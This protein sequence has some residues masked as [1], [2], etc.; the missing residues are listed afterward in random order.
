ML[1][2][3]FVP[4]FTGVKPDQSVAHEETVAH[5]AWLIENG[6]D[7]LVPFGTFGEGASLSLNER[8]RLTESILQVSRDARVVPSIISNSFG[9]I[10]EYIEFANSQ[11]IDGLMV[12]PPGYFRPSSDQALIDFFERVI[13]ISKHPIIAYNFPAMSVELPP[14]VVSK[15]GVWSYA[16]CSR[17]P[18][19]C[20]EG[21][22]GK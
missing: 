6:V 21:S 17:L 11:E 3:L 7:G 22:N 2:G 12:M 1:N 8:I 20:Y 5:A 15:V 13:S 10:K 16:I 18:R 19:V 9:E 14:Q 4:L